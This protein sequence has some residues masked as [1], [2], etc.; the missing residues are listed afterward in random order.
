MNLIDYK[1]IRK[2]GLR[3]FGD[4]GGCFS[5]VDY[6]LLRR[7]CCDV[8][9]LNIGGIIR[10]RIAIAGVITGF[11]NYLTIPCKDSRRH[12]MSFFVSK[13]C[14]LDLINYLKCNGRCNAP[15]HRDEHNGA[16]V[17]NVCWIKFF[18]K[19]TLIEEYLD[20][21]EVGRLQDLEFRTRDSWAADWVFE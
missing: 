3:A 5:R 17:P 21:K 9:N 13:D 2:N 10:P 15:I 12:F 4:N 16:I 11:D 8:I 7:N 6:D 14:E 1:E 20:P 19:N 18:H